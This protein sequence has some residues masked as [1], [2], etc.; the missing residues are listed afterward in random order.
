MLRSHCALQ[1]AWMPFHM[2]NVLAH[3]VSLNADR[4]TAN[5]TRQGHLCL[6]CA[7]KAWQHLTASL[8]ATSSR[9]PRCWR[10]A[11]PTCSNLRDCV[12][13]WRLESAF[14]PSKPIAYREARRRGW[15]LIY[16]NRHLAESSTQAF[17][18]SDYSK[19]CSGRSVVQMLLQYPVNDI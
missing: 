6:A 10:R 17:F 3:D 4:M 1:S 13:L 16:Y 9:W 7:T 5:V 19:G 15:Y 12:V 14:Y 11:L 18:S 2:L 8:S